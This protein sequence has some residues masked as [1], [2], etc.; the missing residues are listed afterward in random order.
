MRERLDALVEELLDKGILYDEARREIER[1]FITLALAR[2]GG[3]LCRTAQLLGW[4]RNTLSRRMAEHRL[5]RR[6]H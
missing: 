5:T 6:S 3:N 1:R 2:S 4:H